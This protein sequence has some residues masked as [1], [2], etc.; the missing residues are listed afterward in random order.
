MRGAVGAAAAYWDNIKHT[1][2]FK[3]Q[4]GLVN[5]DLHRTIPIGMHGDGGAFSH[6]DSLFVLT[7]NSLLGVVMTRAT[8]FLMTVIPKS[9]MVP[10]TM[11]AI[12]KIQVWSFNTM[13]TGIEPLI[14]HIG[15]V[16]NG[17][18][19]YLAGKYKARLAQL[20]GDGDFSPCPVS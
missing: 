2:F 1:E 20:R 8:R 3:S 12:M 5:G 15:E 9:S 13:L 19:T 7:W 6:N 10:E 11:P 17:A 16:S 4:P 14:N 18:K